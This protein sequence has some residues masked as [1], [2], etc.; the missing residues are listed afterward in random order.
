[1]SKAKISGQYVNSVLAK[2]QGVEVRRSQVD[3]SFVAY[4]ASLAMRGQTIPEDKRTRIAEETLD[5]ILRE[6]THPAGGFYSSQD[7]DSEGEEG[8]FFVWTSD[9]ITA[10]LSKQT[11]DRAASIVS[12]I[13]FDPAIIVSR[14]MPS[15]SMASITISSV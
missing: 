6:M 7:A 10:A 5:Y 15:A 13:T 9:E 3:D 1:M 11:P 4:K 14:K 8:K 12:R 2:G